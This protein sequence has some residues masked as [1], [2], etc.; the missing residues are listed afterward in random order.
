MHV[1]L[2]IEFHNLNPDIAF[3][4]LFWGDVLLF[5]PE[6]VSS[7][8]TERNGMLLIFIRYLWPQAQ[9]EQLEGNRRMGGRE[10]RM[11]TKVLRCLITALFSVRHCAVHSV[12]SPSLLIPAPEN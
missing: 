8:R 5:S 11:Q 9:S 3:L 12:P 4:T 10:R 6:A 1:A 2:C 7:L